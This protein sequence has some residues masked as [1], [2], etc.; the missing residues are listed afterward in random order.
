MHLF[1]RFPSGIACTIANR[2]SELSEKSKEFPLE[3]SEGRGVHFPLP[4]FYSFLP[5][6]FV[7]QSRLWFRYPH[8]SG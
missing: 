3:L 1:G 6:S 5:P 8:A 7:N 2:E 4:S